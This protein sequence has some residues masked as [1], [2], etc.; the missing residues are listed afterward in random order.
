MVAI[1]A[2]HSDHL[3]KTH[4]DQFIPPACPLSYYCIRVLIDLSLQF[5]KR[6]TLAYRNIRN[7]V[8][9]VG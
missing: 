3:P 9:L 4:Y 7:P 6:G 8:N 5:A 1:E 2:Q